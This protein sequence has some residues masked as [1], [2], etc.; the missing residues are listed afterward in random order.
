M[1]SRSC[2]LVVIPL[3]LISRL[4]HA[5]NAEEKERTARMACLSGDF[6]QGVSILSELFVDTKDPA[7]IYNQGRCFEQNHRYEDAIARFQ[8]FL[9]VG[10]NLGKDDKSEA[11]KHIADCEN[12]LATQ[13]SQAVAT[14]PAAPAPEPVA[15]VIAPM[16]PVV[17]QI[18]Q[19]NRPPTSDSGSGLRTAGVIVAAV[20]GA[21]L[22]TGVILNF[23]VN[24][25]ASDMQKSDGYTDGKESDRKTFATLGWVGYGVGGACVATGAVLYFLGLRS[26]ATEPPSLALLPAFGVGQAGAFLKGTF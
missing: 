9:R 11:R 26:G 25:M 13:P 17:Q 16:Q 20:G 5:R 22:L 24:S 15:P 14:P 18:Q 8:E 23:K 12:L 1:K 2:L 19:P 7:Y 21:G 10:K 6:A 3:L 4:G